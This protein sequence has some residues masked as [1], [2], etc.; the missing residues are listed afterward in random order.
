M[1]VHITKKL[2]GT[3]EEIIPPAIIEIT[4]SLEG[5]AAALI[6]WNKHRYDAAQALYTTDFG[7]PMQQTNVKMEVILKEDEVEIFI[8]DENERIVI[9]FYGNR[10][11]VILGIKGMDLP[12][13]QD[14]TNFI[15]NLFSSESP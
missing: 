2:N 4:N 15:N 11:Y 14:V 9:H 10:R 5:V 1:E 7:P 12:M 13:Y 3:Y 8:T 6:G